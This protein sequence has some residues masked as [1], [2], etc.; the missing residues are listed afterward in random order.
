MF[1]AALPVAESRGLDGAALLDAAIVGYEVSTRLGLAAGPTHY[2][3]WHNTATIGCFG[4]AAAA[5]RAVELDAERAHHA[6]ALAATMAAGLQQAFRSD[7]LAKPLHGGRAAEAGVLAA[8][9]AARGMTGANDMLEAGFGPAMAGDPDWDAALADLGER[10]NIER[11][12]FKAHACCGHSF[13]ALDA[14]LALRAAHDLQPE[15]IARVTVG[16]YATAVTVVG[17]PQ[18]ETAPEARFSLP[19]CAATALVHGAVGVESFAADR[20]AD[21]ALRRLAGRVEV[22][23]D[24]AAESAFPARRSARVVVETRSGERLEHHAPTRR[25][26]PEAPLGDDD[27]AAKFATLA[28]PVIG[29]GAAAGLLERLWSIDEV[30]DLSL[31]GITGEAG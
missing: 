4:A 29:E 3:H 1:S 20:L 22:D 10:Y 27:L 8:L 6:L 13:A 14:L 17:D 11:T 5:A 25:G 15:A 28:G 19:F 12:T 2:A 7:S 18:P 31:L 21:P 30:A 24:P 23:V 9:S 16:T 26:D